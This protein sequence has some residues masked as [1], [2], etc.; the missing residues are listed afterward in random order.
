MTEALKKTF[1]WNHFHLQI[2]L[3]H[4]VTASKIYFLPHLWLR[5]CGIKKRS[6]GFHL[7]LTGTYHAWVGPGELVSHFS[8][9]ALLVRK[10]EGT[11]ILRGNEASKQTKFKR[12]N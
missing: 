12:I 8:R 3:L 11:V 5:Y 6:P 9:F 1:L 7:R 10:E 2:R 4:Q